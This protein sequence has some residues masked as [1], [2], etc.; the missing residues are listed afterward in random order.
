M[1]G[2]KHA[3]RKRYLGDLCTGDVLIGGEIWCL[4]SMALESFL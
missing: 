1:C 3:L 2:V 4:K